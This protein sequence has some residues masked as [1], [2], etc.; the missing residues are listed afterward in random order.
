MMERVRPYSEAQS[1]LLERFRSV[2]PYMYD[3]RLNE[4]QMSWVK[5]EHD[6]VV[7]LCIDNNLVE[8][9]CEERDIFAKKNGIVLDL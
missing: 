2:L 3:S 6:E 9:I 4:S 1:D 7:Q 5:V 8:E